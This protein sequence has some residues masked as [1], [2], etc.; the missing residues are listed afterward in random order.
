L[1]DKAFVRHSLDGCPYRSHSV[2]RQLYEKLPE[3]LQRDHDIVDIV[4]KEIYLPY[5]L[6]SMIPRSR[7]FWLGA[8]HRLDSY[9]WWQLPAEFHTDVEFLARFR[10]E[11]L[12]AVEVALR[13][14][15]SLAGNRAFWTS[16]IKS[17][18]TSGNY[19]LHRLIPDHATAEIRADREL[20]LLACQEEA[21]VYTIL[22]ARF[23]EDR[24]ILTATIEGNESLDT[25]FFIPL[26]VQSIFPDLALKALQGVHHEYVQFDQ[27]AG[28][29]WSDIEVVKAFVDNRNSDRRDF[30]PLPPDFPD[31]MKNNEGFGLFATKHSYKSAD[32]EGFTSVALRSSKTFMLKAV[33]R[34]P[35][36]LA[37]AVGSLAQDFD[38][39]VMAF[40]QQLYSWNSLFGDHNDIED[41]DYST[42]RDFFY[43]IAAKAREKVVAYEGFTRG[44]LYGLIASPGLSCALPLLIRDSETTKSL[45]ELIAAFAG[46]PSGKEVGRYRAASLNLLFMCMPDPENLSLYCM[47]IPGHAYCGPER[48]GL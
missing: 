19:H 6:P 37:A 20:M 35:I 12:D 30:P 1:H 43:S 22:D 3:T 36:C 2:A 41:Y 27:V 7:A 5:E 34:N 26:H 39:A 46:V 11:D 18:D 10:F 9:L 47:A 24:G 42:E 31:A 33:A 40:S 21:R 45:K 13:D 25:F 44:F 17:R 8:C 32:F 14:S 4:L 48:V 38:V 15:P 23:Q 29:L 28:D 16:V